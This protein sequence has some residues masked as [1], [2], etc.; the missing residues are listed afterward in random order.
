[1][2]EFIS[3]YLFFGN[4]FSENNT[5]LEQYSGSRFKNYLVIDFEDKSVD[6][7]Q[8][9]YELGTSSMLGTIQGNTIHAPSDSYVIGV[10]ENKI[11]CFKNYECLT[12][13]DSFTVIG[14]N[15]YDEKHLHTL[16]Q[17]GMIFIFQFIFLICM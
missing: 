12:L 8:L 9:L 16:L 10:L 17:L 2:K 5:S 1:M 6:R 13:L 3:E 15:N 4:K 14:A 7:D 11:S